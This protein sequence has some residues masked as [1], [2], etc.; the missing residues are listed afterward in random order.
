MMKL[1]PASITAT[2]A[3]SRVRELVDLLSQGDGY[4]TTEDGITEAYQLM[5]DVLHTI[6]HAP[7]IADK[8]ELRRLA[9]IALEA[10]D[11]LEN[12]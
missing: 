7:A 8:R 9:A 2:Q 3:Q 5:V 11:V 6:A 4:L 12:S 10:H 1:K